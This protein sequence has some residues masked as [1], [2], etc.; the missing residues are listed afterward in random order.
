MEKETQKTSFSKAFSLKLPIFEPKVENFYHQILKNSVFTVKSDI[1]K[2]DS[3]FEK[4]R[5]LDN[6]IFIA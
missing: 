2:K 5:G 4:M 3:I 6:T 1:V